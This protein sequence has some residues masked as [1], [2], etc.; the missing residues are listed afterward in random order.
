MKHW[1][2]FA[3]ILDWQFG[4]IIGYHCIVVTCDACIW[5]LGPI[6]Y[7]DSPMVDLGIHIGP[8]EIDI[9]INDGKR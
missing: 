7:I 2:N 5:G 8:V 4:I 1:K 9:R 6:I 3:N